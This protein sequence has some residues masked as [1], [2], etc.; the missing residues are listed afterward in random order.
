MTL[1]VQN[2]R[3]GF[4]YIYTCGHQQINWEILSLCTATAFTLQQPWCSYLVVLTFVSLHSKKLN[5]LLKSIQ[6]K[7]NNILT[8]ALYCN[9]EKKF[10]GWWPQWHLRLIH[11]CSQLHPPIHPLKPPNH[12]QKVCYPTLITDD[13]YYHQHVY[14]HNGYTCATEYTEVGWTGTF[15]HS[16][17]L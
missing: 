15:L 7:Y 17:T 13:T 1:N 6:S 9:S 11:L 2:N 8:V 5:L 10:F 4:Y 14:E 12:H 16:Y 3:T